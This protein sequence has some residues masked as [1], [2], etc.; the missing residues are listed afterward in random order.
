[1][2]V[3]VGDEVEYLPH[4]CHA[5]NKSSATGNY[6]WVMGLKRVRVDTS[7]TPPTREEYVQELSD[8]DLDKYFEWCRR[9]HPEAAAKERDNVVF[10][11]PREA[12]RA[13]VVA[14]NGDGTVDLAIRSNQGGVTLNYPNVKL[15]GK[16]AA[17]GAG[18]EPHTCRAV[19]RPEG[20]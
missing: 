20:E 19:T 7:T 4:Q 18:D 5:Q 16:K 15:A 8:S 17:K 13:R 6:P 12:W 14:V 9:L 2:S 1:M 10:L 3:K 11:R